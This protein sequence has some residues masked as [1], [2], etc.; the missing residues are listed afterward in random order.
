MTAIDRKIVLVVTVLF[1]LVALGMAP[2]GGSLNSVSETY[3]VAFIFGEFIAY[4]VAGMV[5]NP[6]ATLGM[7]AGGAF[8]LAIVRILS[9]LLG[10]IAYQVL[11]GSGDNGA[12]Y[13]VLSSLA[14]PLST[15]VQVALL[16]L[17]GPYVLAALVPDL[18]G[19][20]EAAR[21]LGQAKARTEPTPGSHETSPAG[22][23]VQVF[24]F[25]ELAGVFKKSHGLEGFAI[26]STE[27]LVV[28]RDVPM[29]MDLDAV[30]ARTL[31]HCNAVGVVLMDNGL[32]KVRRVT[33]DC[34]EHTLVVTNLNHN[35]GLLLLF[36]SRVAGEEVA[37]RIAILAKTCR[38]FLQ[39]RYPSL[40][41]ASGLTKD[42]IP[43]E[44]L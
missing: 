14:N 41:M 30:V 32:T 9:T 26:F 10:G 22:G 3:I 38:E 13:E 17:V 1:A 44:S 5:L 23:F 27:G 11:G 39:W 21:L 42:R 20:D 2:M 43:L 12:A 29:R 37:S 15:I 40:P 24:S 34:R 4:F 33:I 25:E 16:L 7:A 36:S 31:D 18:V 28:W 35:F 19:P 8:V 6:R